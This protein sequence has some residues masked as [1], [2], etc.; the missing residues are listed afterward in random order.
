MFIDLHRVKIVTRH[1]H[2]KAQVLNRFCH[3]KFTKES[4]A[5]SL[6]MK[7]SDISHVEHEEHE[8]YLVEFMDGTTLAI[9]FCDMRMTIGTTLVV[10]DW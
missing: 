9:S 1:G 7:L 8:C 4:D 3:L 5:Y 10:K 6:R 2:R